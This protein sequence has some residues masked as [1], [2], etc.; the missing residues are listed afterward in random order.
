MLDI[1]DRKRAEAKVREGQMRLTEAQR[2]AQ[3][4][5][6]EYELATKRVT[7]SDE[8]YRICGVPPEGFDASFESALELVHPSDRPLVERVFAEVSRDPKPFDYQLRIQRPDGEVRT[9]ENH[10]DIVFDDYGQPVRMVGIVQD[11]TEQRR[12]ELA[13]RESE[14]RYR[15]LVETARDIIFAQPRV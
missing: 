15:T 6:W 13:R 3:M 5:T 14:A 7:L 4:G 8:L 11:I 9:I 2:L 10:G 12:E 1:T